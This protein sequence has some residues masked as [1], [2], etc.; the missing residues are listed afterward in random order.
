[1]EV[2][3]IIEQELFSVEASD[4]YKTIYILAG[5][6]LIGGKASDSIG[7]QIY[8]TKFV[9][10]VRSESFRAFVKT[11]T[12]GLFSR[13][14]ARLS[15][16][17]EGTFTYEKEQFVVLHIILAPLLRSEHTT[18]PSFDSCSVIGLITG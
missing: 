3:E 7:W 18:N 4:V 8:R 12:D 5:L 17:E 1:M 14:V 9:F 6:T 10:I 11:V 13:F 15:Q 2:H 16:F